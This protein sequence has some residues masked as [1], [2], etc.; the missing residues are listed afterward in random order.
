M[1]EL[2]L[3]AATALPLLR[4]PIYCSSANTP[5]AIACATTMSSPAMFGDTVPES[6]SAMLP[7]VQAAFPKALCRDAHDAIVGFGLGFA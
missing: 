1:T 2:R 3:H 7:T 4:N 5:V 6:S